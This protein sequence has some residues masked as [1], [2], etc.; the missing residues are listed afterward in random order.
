[1]ITPVEDSGRATR[2]THAAL[3]ESVSKIMSNIEQEISNIEG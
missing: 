1:L 3:V 2:A